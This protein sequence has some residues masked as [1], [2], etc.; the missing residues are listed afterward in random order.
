MVSTSPR[1]RGGVHLNPLSYAATL[2]TVLL[3][4]FTIQ[5]S[6]CFSVSN[7]PDKIDLDGGLIEVVKNKASVN[8]LFKPSKMEANYMFQQLNTLTSSLYN[9]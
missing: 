5:S 8:H 1:T 7:M 6:L 3:L 4:L 2:S 9:L